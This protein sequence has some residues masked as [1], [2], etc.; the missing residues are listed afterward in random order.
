MDR[1][2][3]ALRDQ[4]ARPTLRRIRADRRRVSAEVEPLLAVIETLLFDRSLD[5][6]RLWRESG[7]K[8]WVTG[9]FK[10]ELNV[11]PGAYIGNARLEV[12]AALLE[13]SRLEVFKVAELVG[14]SVTRDAFSR[15]FQRWSGTTPASYRARARAN[16]GPVPLERAPLAI[17]KLIEDVD[18]ATA[19][20]DVEGAR[21][22]LARAEAELR[23][24]QVADLAAR[25][26]A[27]LHERAADRTRDGDVDRAFDDLHLARDCYSA[28]GELPPAIIRQRRQIPVSHVT[29]EALL[30]A[31]CPD[32]RHRLADD[33]GRSMRRNLRQA[34]RLVPRDDPWFGASCD[35]CYRVVWSAL[36]RAR[37][38][39]MSDA[40]K[41]WWLSSKVD[42][43]DRR[44]PPS[45]GRFIA[46]MTE[47]ERLYSGDQLERRSYAGLAVET[48]VALGDP[49]LEAEARL[50]LAALL[51]ATLEFG[52]ARRQMQLIGTNRPSGSALW[53]SALRTRVKGLLERY[54]TNY[55]KALPLLESSA[56]SYSA[57]DPHVS[58]LLVMQQA[59]VY[60]DMADY[61]RSIE[62][63]HQ[64]LDLLDGRRDPLPGTGAVPIHLATAFGLLGKWEKAELAL[65][66]C[67]FD[68][69][70]HL[71]LAAIEISTRGCL[72]LLRGRLRMSADLLLE[73]RERFAE[74]NMPRPAALV[75]SYAV[76]A[77]GRQGHRALAIQTAVAALSFFQAAG[78][79]RDTLEV[80]GR[81]RALLEAEVIDTAAVAAKVRSLARRN[82]GWLPEPVEGG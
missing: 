53:L 72:A 75:A 4:A 52:D 39:L 45:R 70:N 55:P 37:L 58:G 51:A 54:R 82:G 50:W 12:G 81:L 78:C 19:S 60:L 35:E 24:R 79:D 33:E 57:L 59:N 73:A 43:K 5:V 6:N 67:R 41:A 40:W 10:D 56:G 3:T 29:D 42:P 20:G 69:E 66:R 28:A 46:V 30:S 36:S 18:R 48:A 2:A 65:S 27:S 14:Y 61:E 49:H 77:F 32:C 1:H 76:E 34:L 25:L 64:A 38:G 22:G 68:R 15:A 16:G 8:K 80:F 9:R 74:L 23:D 17:D 62:L 11:G 44:S 7:V 13:G 26:G 63:N 21:R 71:G 47:V 31:L